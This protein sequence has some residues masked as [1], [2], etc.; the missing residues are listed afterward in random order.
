ML[1]K[2]LKPYI[3]IYSIEDIEEELEE[4]RLARIEEYKLELDQLLAELNSPATIEGMQE[5]Q[6]KEKEVIYLQK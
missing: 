1:E 3:D 5:R 4:D 6:K 2:E